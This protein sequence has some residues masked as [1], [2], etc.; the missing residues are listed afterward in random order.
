MH[1][2]LSPLNLPSQEVFIEEL[3]LIQENLLANDL[4]IE[5]EYMSEESMKPIWGWSQYLG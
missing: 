2:L 3:E 5:G 1:S 4:V